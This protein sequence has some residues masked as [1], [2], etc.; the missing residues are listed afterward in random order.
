MSFRIKQVPFHSFIFSHGWYPNILKKKKLSKY[1]WV[2]SRN[3]LQWFL[4]FQSFNF[5][6]FLLFHDL[7]EKIFGIFFL[8]SLFSP[9]IFECSRSVNS[10]MSFWCFQIFQKNNGIFSRI[11]A[12][13]KRS[14]QKSSV[15]ESK[16]V[17]QLEVWCALIFLMYTLGFLDG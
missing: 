16:Q 11:S 1:E 4:A 14:N 5:M 3:I 17:I 6:N 13:E 2:L 8:I 9:P 10:K 15:R 7:E 12:S